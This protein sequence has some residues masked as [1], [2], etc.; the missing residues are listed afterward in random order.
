MTRP[1]LAKPADMKSCILCITQKPAAFFSFIL[2][3]AVFRLLQSLPCFIEASAAAA[4]SQ[5][6]SHHRGHI[7]EENRY[8][9]YRN[10]TNAFRHPD[11]QGICQASRAGI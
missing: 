11:H 2:R 1:E 4:N 10:R 7:R 9:Q 6:P 8:E 3:V 5:N